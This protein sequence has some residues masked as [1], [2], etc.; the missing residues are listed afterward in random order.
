[1]ELTEAEDDPAAATT[2]SGSESSDMEGLSAEEEEAEAEGEEEA[3]EGAPRKRARTAELRRPPTAEELI[4]LRQTQN[5][6]HSNLFQ[7]QTTEMLAEITPSEK[8]ASSLSAWL[9]ELRQWLA[10]LPTRPSRPLRRQP[11][12]Q[13]SGLAV[14]LPVTLP[15]EPA[16]DQ[17]PFGF[18]PPTAVTESGA[19]A[20][21]VLERG[22]TVDL[23]LEMPPSCVQT[24]DIV[25]A[26]Y[27]R[28]RAL[29]LTFLATRLRSCELV[30]SCEFTLL[31][32]DP[33]RPALLLR[34]SA[35]GARKHSVRLLPVPPA[36]VFPPERLAPTASAVQSKWLTGEAVPPQREAPT[37]RY[38]SAVLADAAAVELA[39]WCRR[40]VDE[41]P[42]AR[43]ALR[44]L[45]VWLRQRGLDRGAGAVDLGVLT[46]FV[47][48]LFQ[49][50]RLSKLMSGYQVMRNVWVQLTKTDWAAEGITFVANPTGHQPAL[51]IFKE[52]F[53][54]V[55]VAPSGFLNAAWS[56][57]G[58]TY[59]RL[60]DEAARAVAYLD[61]PDVD[62]FQALF[63]TPLPFLESMDHVFHIST[64]PLT[65][66]LTP[67]RDY[68]CGGLQAVLPRV[69]DTLRRGLTDRVLLLDTARVPDPVWTPAEPPPADPDS[70][71]LGVRLSPERLTSIVDKGPDSE[72]REASAQF[73]RFWGA[74][75]GTRRFQDGSIQ[76]AVV[77]RAETLL[78]HRMVCRQIVAHLLQ[79]HFRVPPSALRYPAD[80]PEALLSQTRQLPSFPYGAGEEA[81]LALSAAFGRLSAVLRRLEGIPLAVAAVL[82]TA[83]ALRHAAPFPPLPEMWHALSGRTVRE[84][85]NQ[86]LERQTELPLPY[87]P[88][89]D[90]VVQLEIS[91]KW[92][93]EP[94]AIRRV[95]SALHLQI[96]EELGGLGLIASA[97][98]DCVLVI[99]D[100]YLFRLCVA[101]PREAAIL[102]LRKQPE[103]AAELDRRT[104]QLPKLTSALGALQRQYPAYSASVRLALRWLSAQMM[105]DLVPDIAAELLMAQVYIGS[106]PL[107][108]PQQPSAALLR[109]LRLLAHTDWRQQPLLV[110]LNGELTA[111][112]Q[113][114]LLARFRT[115]R[116]RLPALVVFTPYDET[117][118]AWTHE[119]PTAVVLQ[120]VQKLASSAHEL[121][122]A[123]LNAPPA[124]ADPLSDWR[125][126]FRPPLEAFDIRIRLRRKQIPRRHQ[127]VDPAGKQSR[128]DPYS[129][130]PYE[131]VPAAEFDPVQRLV[132]ELRAAAAGW[133]LVCHDRCGGD[134]IGVVVRPDAL[135]PRPLA[136]FR[137]EGDMPAGR[138]GAEVAPNV[139]GFV[140]L[141]RTLG[142]ELVEHVELEA[143]RLTAMA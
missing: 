125:A 112:Q 93:E 60:R 124:S 11:W 32:S 95:R 118:T 15:E 50:R 67:S 42:A 91:G 63:M 86:L 123:Q 34:P 116:D 107:P 23:L 103:A 85:A 13:K 53:E 2:L 90:V 140:D 126:I 70:L 122:T 10:A 20:A 113:A 76:E 87:A 109:W 4:S 35:R 45:A 27:A 18:A 25:N 54:V 100:G 89:C 117:G 5:L 81:E 96:R 73:R 119:R 68:P 101:Y 121:L 29:Y 43:T 104:G 102:R 71:T 136:A 130:L 84:G 44:M 132:A 62:S 98:R 57:S 24:G 133:A 110:G 46:L 14:P 88:V 128:A 52:S 49:E 69:L 39:D 16:A 75:A 115:E 37:P 137:C 30:S 129:K 94:E 105:S 66:D 111:E 65:A 78:E 22:G 79:L 48:W 3:E 41:A 21:G 138:G 31:G 40:R 9:S 1:M 142:G 51:Q 106:A 26:R 99:Y 55:L 7:L 19:L 97:R 127:A 64:A 131:A 56:V 59:S 135:R 83:P 47:L 28:K 17:L 61:D 82:A 120:H 12:L 77:W 141:A 134:V 36:G 72:S 6:F 114:P 38:N 74:L 33:L 80:G 58:A 8:Q 92:P 108:V 143:D 139:A